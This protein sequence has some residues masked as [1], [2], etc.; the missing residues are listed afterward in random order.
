MKNRSVL[1]C[2]ALVLLLAAGCGS[3]D[4]R[5]DAPDATENNESVDLLCTTEYDPAF[6]KNEDFAT[7]PWSA[8]L[9]RYDPEYLNED[10]LLFASALTST[11]H[12]GGDK[13]P[14]FGEGY[15]I[16]KAYEQLGFDDIALFSYP[17]SKY[18][19][20]KDACG[21]DSEDNDF[22]FSIGHKVME[23]EEGSFDLL[24][25]ILRGTVTQHEAIADSFGTMKERP[26]SNGYTTYDGYYG[27]ADDVRKGL[28]Y[29]EQ[30]FATNRTGKQVYLICGHSLGGASANLLAQELTRSGETV[31]GFTFGAL[32][33]ITTS[34][35]EKYKNIWNCM[36]Y[37]DTFGPYG[38]GAPF[39]IGYKPSN[40][41]ST[42]YN[43]FGNVGINRHFYE[44]GGGDVRYANHHMKSYYLG[45]KDRLYDFGDHVSTIPTVD[46]GEPSDESSQ[47]SKP[48]DLVG[49]WVTKDGASIEFAESGAFYFDWGFGYEETGAYSVGE[50]TGAKSFRI[51]LDGTSL[52]SLMKMLYG[53]M[54]S[55][56]HFEILITD[57][58]TIDLVQVYGGYSAATSG[59]KLRF[60]RYDD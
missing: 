16:S 42:F 25:I 57:R 35:T 29:V 3:T 8:G 17:K 12:D 11:A 46:S 48:F 4:Y 40:G 15:Y 47:E 26:W 36:N 56:Y 19:V 21:F 9:F 49:L 31:Y 7:A 2:L 59:C 53:S 27:F 37:Y 58:D 10:L 55:S 18:L 28:S 44:F 52:I 5:P 23:D 32:N 51:Q 60:S 33:S 20:R 22:A 34:E 43:K 45:A 24:T 38:E 14:H 30:R 41:G 54:D 6:A 50:A 1:L 39:P 13:D